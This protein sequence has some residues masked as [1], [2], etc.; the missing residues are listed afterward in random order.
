MFAFRDC[1]CGH[2]SN[3]KILIILFL[4]KESRASTGREDISNLALSAFQKMAQ[5]H[6]H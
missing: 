2:Y 6:V 1:V 4:V 5:C 3:V